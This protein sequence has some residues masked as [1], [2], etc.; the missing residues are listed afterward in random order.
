MFAGAEE[1]VFL[2]MNALLSKQDHVIVQWP[3]YQSLYEV[4]R[5][6]SA[7]VSKWETNFE[8]NWELDLDILKKMI[9]PQTKAIM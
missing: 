6:C 1:G 3:C 8:N 7:Q 2:F 5:E 9:T 4:A